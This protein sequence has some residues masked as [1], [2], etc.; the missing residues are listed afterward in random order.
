VGK[1]R[2][3]LVAVAFGTSVAALFAVSVA[4][5]VMRDRLPVAR[6]ST[7]RYLYV[8]SDEAMKRLTIAFQALAADVYW[9]RAIQ[10]YGGDRLSRGGGA[11]YELLYPLLDIT[12][13]LDPRFTIAYRFGAIFL[14]EPYPGGPGRPDL[15]IA[16]LRKGLLAEP[17]KWQYLHDIG[18]VHYWQRG[19]AREAARWFQRASEIPGAPNWLKP[20]AATMLIRGGDRTASRFLWQQVRDSADQEWLRALAERRLLQLRA[21][22]LIDRLEPVVRRFA[23]SADPPYTWERLVRAG[24]L[25]GVPLDPTG[26]PFEL[27]PWSAVVRVSRQS[28]LFPMPTE[29]PAGLPPAP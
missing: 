14:A 22:D 10:H 3:R 20:L 12:T 21:L 19:D 1:S 11:K 29:P 27:G 6:P 4:L 9:I 26:V 5:Q 25:Q 23:A 7:E 24:V 2:E 16:L 13:T 17:T 15:A 28:P 18:F 8:R